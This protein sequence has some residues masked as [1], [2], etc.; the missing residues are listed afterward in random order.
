MNSLPINAYLRKSR[1]GWVSTCVLFAWI[2][3]HDTAL[4]VMSAF[5][6]NQGILNSDLSGRKYQEA[7][8]QRCESDEHL[9]WK[10]SSGLLS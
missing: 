7:T 10:T 9:I 4:G 8:H 5:K 2:I 3:E 1:D 6:I